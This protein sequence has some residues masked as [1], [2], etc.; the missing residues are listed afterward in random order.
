MTS[1]A[2]KLLARKEGKPGQ[3][4]SKQ[5][6]PSARTP[7]APVP[8]SLSARLAEYPHRMTL[9]EVAEYLAMNA[10]HVSNLRESGELEMFDISSPG[11]NRPTWRVSRASVAAFEARR[12]TKPRT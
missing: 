10:D 3:T 8:V 7:A 5:C 2:E 11:T 4:Q 1:Y 12:Q 9:N 6:P